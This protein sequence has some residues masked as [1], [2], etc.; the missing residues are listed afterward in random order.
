LKGLERHFIFV[1]PELLRKRKEL[2]EKRRRENLRALLKK[3]S[4][5]V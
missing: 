2:G 1:G 4:E 5:P 3:R